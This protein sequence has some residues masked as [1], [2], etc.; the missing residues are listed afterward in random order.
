MVTYYVADHLGSIVQEADASGSVTLQRDYDYAYVNNGPSGAVD[1]TG[2]IIAH[3]GDVPDWWAFAQDLSS[4]LGCSNW[5]TGG[6]LVLS[7]I[8]LL[9][10]L[11]GLGWID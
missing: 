1:P 2:L 8:G 5:G 7:T 10:V 9:P 6:S 3:P 11:T 4:F